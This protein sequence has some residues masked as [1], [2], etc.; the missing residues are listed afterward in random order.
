M[1]TGMV[2]CLMRS[3][4][5]QCLMK[6][7]QGRFLR[8][9]DK[10]LLRNSHTALYPLIER[11]LFLTKRGRVR[12]L[13]TMDRVRSLWKSAPAQYLMNLVQVLLMSDFHMALHL[14][15]EELVLSLTN[16]EPVPC[17]MRS[18]PAPYLMNWVRVLLMC[19]FHTALHL[20]IGE[21]VLSLMNLEVPC[22]PVLVPCL[23]GSRLVLYR[24]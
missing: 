16:S 6:S 3:E 15:T 17:L 19:D 24:V 8:S 11:E 4:L 18:G 1:S 9:M 14:T 22:Q 5:A 20:T 7:E 21:L 13:M 12:S 10:G 23:M 2:Q